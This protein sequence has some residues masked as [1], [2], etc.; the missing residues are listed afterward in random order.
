MAT[1]T[2]ELDAALLHQAIHLTG[3]VDQS[4]IVTLA[5]KDLVERESAMGQPPVW[6]IEFMQTS[7]LFREELARRPVRQ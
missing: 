6:L 7:P 1:Y 4:E 3:I 5:L 2:L